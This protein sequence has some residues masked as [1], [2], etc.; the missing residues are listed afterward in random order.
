MIAS[1]A[2]LRKVC[3]LADPPLGLLHAR[4]VVHDEREVASVA[5]GRLVGDD[6]VRDRDVSAVTAQQGRLADP[7]PVARSCGY[8]LPQNDVVDV[9][10]MEVA[11][12]QESGILLA[13]RQS[14]HLEAGAVDVEY[15]AVERRHP[16]KIGRALQ[17]HR[18]ARRCLLRGSAVFAFLAL[19]PGAPDRGN[20]ALHPI[21]EDVVL[22]ARLQ[23]LNGAVLTDGAGEENEGRR[24]E[25]LPD[26]RECVKARER[27][28]GEIRENDVEVRILKA[29]R[30]CLL[31]PRDLDRAV[32]P[33]L[34]QQGLHKLSVLATVLD[35]QD[36]HG[37]RCSNASRKQG[38]LQPF[39]FLL[40]RKS[41][42]QTLPGGGSFRT[43]Q[44]T[45]SLLIAPMMNS[46]KST[47]FTT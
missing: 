33:L 2:R 30:E 39:R 35:V 44:K 27:A 15:P 22:R 40:G 36:L 11:H 17:Q 6:D 1:R 31:G 16:D 37:L 41:M 19:A 23:R 3:L 47:G 12:A 13:V 43:A 32:G 24:R 25:P 5:L 8:R 21:L 20:E 14:D 7:G 34:R 28:E 38:A 9:P 45:P 18:K 26:N 10:R 46:S 42:A 29:L 4:D